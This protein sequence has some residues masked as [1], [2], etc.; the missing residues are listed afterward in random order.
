MSG[1]MGRKERSGITP[2]AIIIALA[3]LFGGAVAYG[4]VGL[5]PGGPSSVA[6]HGSSGAVT[7]SGTR[8]LAIGSVIATISVGV[9]PEALAFDKTDN[10]V[11]VA[12]AAGGGT[13][14][15]PG[16][17]SVINPATNTV[18]AWVPLPTFSAGIVG[19]DSLAYDGSNGDLYVMDSNNFHVSVLNAATNA[20]LSTIALG[21]TAGLS[22]AFSLDTT[23]GTLF[24]VSYDNTSVYTINTASNVL[25][26][27]FYTEPANQNGAQIPQYICFDSANNDLY[28]PQENSGGPSIPTDIVVDSASSTS[29]ITNFTTPTNFG[30]CAY[31]PTN[32]YVYVTGG[33]QLTVINGATNTLVT[34]ISYTSQ[35]G[36]IEAAY[37]SANGYLY[38]SDYNTASV[39]VIDTSTGT[40]LGTIPVATSPGAI[41]YDSTNGDIYVAS[42]YSASTPGTISVI[43]PS[44]GSAAS[45]TIT[46]FTASPAS[47][48]LGAT[49]F[50][51]VT[52]TG[53]ALPYTYAYTGLPAG[54]TGANA[55]RLVCSPT[56]A[57]T[58][59]VQVT[60]TDSSGKT[61]T[62]SVALI[63][64]T[65]T[66]PPGGSG[67]GGGGN[68]DLL[69]VV[70]A[71]VAVAA[72]AGAAVYFLKFR[73]PKVQPAMQPYPQA[74]TPPP[75]YGQAPPPAGPPGGY[76]P[77]PPPF[78]G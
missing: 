36:A 50:L 10:K 57:G 49:T 43:N 68:N 75:Q 60:V 27:N 66:P 32:G 4:T 9:D 70:V 62:A 22:G 63:V 42:T 25:T 58:T 31:D 71:V 46:S 67:G 21:T 17:L 2:I 54:C 28:I 35:E 14:T 15:D 48:A 74:Q 69:Y 55:P 8:P 12:N 38:V 51:N 45:P 3:L 11:F 64:T 65:G 29:F 73:K 52:V 78:Q 1:I 34:N 44:G 33:N 40:V 47:I 20:N 76:P 16:N 19:P 37:D 39:S 18:S 41:T 13:A 61:A 6:L 7:S 30:G 23:S 5:R 59:S 56:S 72:I 77:P 24:F 26:G 53:G